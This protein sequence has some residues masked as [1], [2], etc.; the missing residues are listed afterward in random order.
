M[1][2]ESSQWADLNGDVKMKHSKSSSEILF[3]VDPTNDTVLVKG[4]KAQEPSPRISGD[5]KHILD[6]SVDISRSDRNEVKTERSFGSLIVPD[7]EIAQNIV[8]DLEEQKQ[9]ES[10]G[11]VSDSPRF[12]FDQIRS[13]LDQKSDDKPPS[14][15]SFIKKWSFKDREVFLFLST[16]ATFILIAVLS[17]V[18]G[19]S[20][21]KT[22]IN[23]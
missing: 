22:H 14:A 10:P 16:I 9:P 13:N 12:R 11:I 17:M 3:S 21:L 5:A 6:S 15:G 23:N 2:P 4:V 7:I 19:Y 18:Y 1:E 8:G 20:Y